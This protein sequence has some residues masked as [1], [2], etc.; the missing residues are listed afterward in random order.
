VRFE[1]DV[2]KASWRQVSVNLEEF[3]I[4]AD[5]FMRHMNRILVGTMLQVASGRRSLESFCAL[6][7]GRP[8][9]D[10]GPTAPPYGLYFAGA[11]YGEKEATA[12]V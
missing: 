6:L 12:S 3:W 2:F 5:T 7:E 1:R 4:E 11:S 10:A 8:R 9:T